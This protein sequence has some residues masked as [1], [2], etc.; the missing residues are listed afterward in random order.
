MKSRIHVEHNVGKHIRGR[1]QNSHLSCYSHISSSL[2]HLDGVSNLGVPPA[3][4]SRVQKACLEGQEVCK[5]YVVPL[6]SSEQE[7]RLEAEAET[8]MSNKEGNL[9][10]KMLNVGMISMV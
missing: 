6:S 4:K 3:L 1:C 8:L 5:G 9:L 7:T 2:L 10:N